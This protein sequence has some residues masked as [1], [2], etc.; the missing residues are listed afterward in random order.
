[1]EENMFSMKRSLFTIFS[2]LMIVAM[3][4]ACSPATPPAPAATSTPLPVPPTYTPMAAKPTAAAATT[5]PEPTQPPAPTDT[6]APSAIKNAWGV[7]LPADAAPLDQQF[8]RIMGDDGGTTCDFAVSVYKR[9]SSYCAVFTTPMVRLN[10]NFEILPGGAL[11]WEPSADGKTWTFHLDPKLMWSDGNKVTADDVV[12]TFQYQADPKHAWDFTWFWSDIVNF[13]EAVAGKVPTT[14][15]G[16]KKVDDYTVTF[17]TKDPSPYFPSKALY[18][19]PM[20]KAAFDK[21]G[22]YYNNKPET[23]VSSSPWILQEWTK[24]K[25]IVIG[26]NTKYTGSLK[27]FME[28]LVIILASSG[29]GAFSAYQN[30]EV[31]WNESFSPADVD[32]ISN[33]PELNKQYHPGYGDFRTYYLGYNTAEKPFNDLKVRQAFSK[34]IDRDSI[35]QN[36]VKRQGIAAY[37]FLMPGF[38]ASNSPALKEEDI[39]KYDVAKAKELLASAGYPDG[40]GFPKLEM[41]L[42]NEGDLNKNVASAIASMLKDNLGIDV[43]VSNKEAKLFMDTLNSH[44]LQFYFL[45]YGFD[46]LDPSNMLGIWTTGGRHAWSNPEFDKLVKDAS[47]LTGDDAK[48]T[49]MFQDA[50]KVLVDDAGG[51]FLYHATPGTIYKPYLKGEELEPD[52]V[53]LAAWHWPGLEDIGMLFP[54]IYV[55]K[56]VAT[57]G[58]K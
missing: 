35:I 41:W 34:A 24:G 4:A 26:P 1:M 46:Y 30:G 7:T 55:S 45:S 54:T 51:I 52:K 21:Y 33:D 10:K 48:R 43:E 14:D 42:R 9:P 17:T 19:R 2:V 15:I 40:K 22:E 18:I 58:R 57:S 20:S 44:K 28:K 50:E 29:T 8:I 56:D 25:Q 36:V 6:A 38:P 16:V 5:A 49:K 47:A 11:S 3:L 12:S 27:P 39:N 32:L 31:D 37:S 23:A 53:G 13:D